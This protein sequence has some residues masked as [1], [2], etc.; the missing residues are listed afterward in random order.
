MAIRVPFQVPYG[1]S[2]G[3]RIPLRLS[4]GRTFR[5]KIPEN[6]FY[7]DTLM[8][9]IPPAPTTGNPISKKEEELPEDSAGP[10]MSLSTTVSGGVDIN[11]VKPCFSICAAFPTIL[12]QTSCGLYLPNKKS[13]MC[14]LYTKGELLCIQTELALCKCGD[15]NKSCCMCCQGEVEC[16]KPTTI[17]KMVGQLFCLDLRCAFPCD[18]E[19]PCA[20]TIL[21]LTICAANPNKVD[22]GGACGACCPDTEQMCC[23]C[24]KFGEETEEDGGAPAVAVNDDDFAPEESGVEAMER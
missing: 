12:G 22:E 9:N 10:P 5:I 6:A 19:V 11:D 17:L 15:F 14:G 7:P 2:P 8:L 21:G 18:K 24:K 16:I 4:D 20:C 13:K 1:V 3:E 23:T